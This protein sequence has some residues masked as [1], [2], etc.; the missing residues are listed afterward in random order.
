MMVG[1]T[2]LLSFARSKNNQLIVLAGVDPDLTGIM[3]GGSGQGS[4]E[5]V[6]LLCTDRARRAVN[7]GAWLGTP[8]AEPNSPIPKIFSS[9][10]QFIFLLLVREILCCKSNRYVGSG[11]F[12]FSYGIP[13]EGD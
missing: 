3:V 10:T 8:M 13:R 7:K 6:R 4:H 11:I 2:S 5:Q 12:R 1:I 9:K